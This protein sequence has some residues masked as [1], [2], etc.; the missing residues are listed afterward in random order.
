MVNLSKLIMMIM[1]VLVL[2]VQVL[3]RLVQAVRLHVRITRI[4]VTLQPRSGSLAPRGG[5]SNA[6]DANKPYSDS[7]QIRVIQGQ[8]SSIG[9]IQD[10]E[11]VWL[12]T[13]TEEEKWYYLLKLER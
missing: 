2:V 12:V 10:D 13:G 6:C 8:F 4:P 5:A 7:V 9:S 3:V 11:E 1:V